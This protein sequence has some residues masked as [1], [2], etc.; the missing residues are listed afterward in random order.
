MQV[1]VLVC[2]CV[3]STKAA[4][5]A[6]KSSSARATSRQPTNSAGNLTHFV[7]GLHALRR[8]DR[9]YAKQQLDNAI[10]NID[11]V[12]GRGPSARQARSYTGEEAKKFFLGESHERAFACLLRG[13]LYLGD[14]E[15]DN[16]RACFKSASFHDID[17]KA[18]PPVSD[19]FLAEYLDWKLAA[20]QAGTHSV[21]PTD[22]KETF[23]NFPPVDLSEKFHIVVE[24]GSPPIKRAFGQHDH[25]LGY[26]TKYPWFQGLEVKVNTKPVAV[27]PPEDFFYHATS[28]GSRDMDRI[29]A[30]KSQIKAATGSIG[31]AAL[32]SAAAMAV[33][34][35][36]NLGAAL[37]V[38]G[39]GL[40]LKGISAIGKATVD[41]R[42]WTN[43]P[44][45][46]WYSAAV[47]NAGTNSLELSFKDKF[48]DSVHTIHTNFVLYPTGAN[49][50]HILF[51][52]AVG[53]EY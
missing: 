32:V 46:L 24:V 31:D 16:A 6:S 1:G 26:E 35:S 23:R 10:E 47:A 30:R 8:G 41:T 4:D 49:R 38:G 51:L 33:S 5:A 48:G 25:I 29:L 17:I 22:F 3:P 39:V 19:L 45:F 52:S 14:S 15:L 50:H 11:G 27:C 40:A 53:H 43:Q 7:S 28:R 42:Y 13:L 34:D 21:L 37:V 18:K 20:V 36:D 44:R 2:F 12:F 9:E